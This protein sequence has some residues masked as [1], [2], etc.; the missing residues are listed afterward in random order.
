MS[1]Q[2]T[3]DPMPEMDVVGQ[4][5]RRWTCPK[6][7]GDVVRVPRHGWDRVVSW[8]VPVRRF[9][10]LCPVCRWEGLLRID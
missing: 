2:S 1:G 5:V 10:C 9:Q 6:C 7:E 3:L 8:F 4:P